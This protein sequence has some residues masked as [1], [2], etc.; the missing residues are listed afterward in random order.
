MTVE[1]QVSAVSYIVTDSAIGTEYPITF[2]YID[3]RDV[4]AY[5]IRVINNLNVRTELTYNIDYTVVGQTFTTLTEIPL[6][7]DTKLAIYR[8]TERSQNILWVD[9]QAVYPPNIMKSDDKLTLIVQELTE[10]VSRSIRTSITDPDPPVSSQDLYD[11]VNRIA[12]RAEDAVTAAEE[13][14][15]SAI[16]ARDR[17]EN[18]ADR[19]EGA[20][21]DLQGLSIAVDDVPYGEI[22]YGSYNPDT[23]MLT[24]SIPRGRTGKDSTVPGPTGATGADGLPGDTGPKGD[25]G[26]ITGELTGLAFG[27][28]RITDTGMLQFAYVGDGEVPQMSIRSDGQIE[29]VIP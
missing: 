4:K 18:A 7:G 14:L 19:A 11:E 29:V 6:E 10:E 25:P 5:H 26:T 17:A 27:N 2:Q 15:G 13:V 21:S 9:G 20:V 12:N 24:V 3:T 16:D 1:S 8:N 23:N 22:G 28:F